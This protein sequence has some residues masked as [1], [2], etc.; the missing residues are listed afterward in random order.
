MPTQL[1]AQCFDNII[2]KQK[3][4]H[5]L[6]IHLFP[7]FFYF[8][9]EGVLSYFQVDMHV[10]YLL[11]K[12]TSQHIHT[13]IAFSIMM[14]KLYAAIKT[15]SALGNDRHISSFSLCYIYVCAHSVNS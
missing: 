7:F 4:T 10:L 15:H 14:N 2:I 3:Q 12:H 1:I 6:I 5:N 11:Y 13:S 8:V 9:H